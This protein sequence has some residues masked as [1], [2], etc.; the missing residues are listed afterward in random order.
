MDDD[1][2]PLVKG[3]VAVSAIGSGVVASVVTV[4]TFRGGTVPVLGW[5]IDG[6][7]V[8][9]IF[10]MMVG[11]PLITMVGYWL[12]MLVGMPLQWLLG[13]RRRRR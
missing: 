3:I 11:F 1:L 10:A 4:I 12:G 13:R 2:H 6:G 7:A 9:G 8:P 5:E